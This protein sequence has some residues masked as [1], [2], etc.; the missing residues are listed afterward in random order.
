MRKK[1]IT[2]IGM[3]HTNAIK[4]AVSELDTSIP[5]KVINL[6]LPEYKEKYMISGKASQ[7]LAEF[8]EDSYVFSM[9][10]GN[11]HNVLGLIEHPK[12]LD[13]YMPGDN[14]L[15][16]SD[17][18]I[19]PYNMIYEHISD[20]LTGALN[21][22]TR[23]KEMACCRITHISSPPP[24]YDETHLINNPGIFKEKLHLGITPPDIRKKLYDIHTIVFES[25]CSKN[26]IGI[27]KPP[28]EALD[29]QGFLQEKYWAN[30]PTHANEKYG[31]LVVDQILDLIN[32]PNVTYNA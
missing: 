4:K 8:C 1:G 15:K 31:K 7:S 11:H 3:S 29:E 30:N 6:N 19:L 18:M 13:F 2:I 25:Y 10:A 32:N 26:N 9:V 22:I 21:N 14:E 27:L 5:F 23:I 12:K 24:I 16:K 28:S 17:R 20:S